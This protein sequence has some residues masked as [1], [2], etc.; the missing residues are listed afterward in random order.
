[1]T[2]RYGR[3]IARGIV[4]SV[5]SGIPKGSERTVRPLA[6]VQV[7]H[8]EDPGAKRGAEL[9]PVPKMN[10]GVHQSRYQKVPRS[11]DRFPRDASRR[12]LR[13]PYDCI[14]SHGDVD[15]PST[16]SAIEHTDVPNQEIAVRVSRSVRCYEH[17]CE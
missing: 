8:G 16:D 17:E 2:S 12:V 14:V 4:A 9:L 15:D 6:G 13:D 5:A 11:I 3:R 1:M 10:M 7:D